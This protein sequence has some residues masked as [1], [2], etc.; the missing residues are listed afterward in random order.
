MLDW[1]K[2][3]SGHRIKIEYEEVS[4]ESDVHQFLIRAF[5]CQ[6]EDCKETNS[7]RFF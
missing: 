4:K 6:C 5:H 1:I 3:H 2:K 7:F